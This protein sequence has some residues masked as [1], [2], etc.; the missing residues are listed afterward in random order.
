MFGMFRREM[1]ESKISVLFCVLVSVYI[2]MIV[3]IT[4]GS[5]EV[6]AAGTTYYVDA[7]DGNDGS[8]GLS[9]GN[10]WKTLS[11]VNGESFSPGDTISFQKGEV[12]RETL[13]VPSS[14]DASN[15]ITFGSYGTGD[16]P[17]FL[18]LPGQPRT[19]IKADR[20]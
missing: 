18:H 5:K 4:Q 2:G 12:W 6:R 20:R 14:G 7:T 17:V 16:N 1:F 11:K 19:E 10:A 8:D 15:Q 9:E 3:W 13:T